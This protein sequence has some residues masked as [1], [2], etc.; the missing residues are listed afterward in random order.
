MSPKNLILSVMF[1]PPLCLC[2]H[3]VAAQYNAAMDSAYKAICTLPNDSAKLKKLLDFSIQVENTDT[4]LCKEVY[5]NTLSI[6]R[7]I[8]SPFFESKTL[9]Y[10]GIF[11]KNHKN[12]ATALGCLQ[13]A[14]KIARSA[15]IDENMG[16]ALANM[17]NV[18]YA[19]NNIE[20]ATVKS[21]EAV[22]HLEK[23]GKIRLLSIVLGNLCT[24]FENQRMY[25]K[26]I[27]YGLKAVQ[28]A[29]QSK[30]KRAIGL[31]YNNLSVPYFRIGDKEKSFEVSKLA[32]SCLREFK[33]HQNLHQ[34]YQ[35]I[36]SYY[37]EVNDV[38]NAR[39]YADSS[40]QMAIASNDDK[41][42]AKAK[43]LIGSIA[44]EAKDFAKAHK[45]ISEAKKMV[46]KNGEIGLQSD[47]NKLMFRL[48]D[49][50]GKTNESAVA[51]LGKQFL[52]ADSIKNVQILT[53]ITT[54]E[55]KFETEKKQLQIVQLQKEKKIQELSLHQKNIM[56]YL[57]L[58]GL[59]SAFAIGFLLYRNNR[60][61]HQIAA[62]KEALHQQQIKE[63]E[64]EKQLLAVSGM[65]QSQ[66]AERSRMAKD[67]HDGLGGMLSGIKLNLSSMKG[68]MLV[69]EKDALLF[70]K[71]ISQLDGAISEMRRVAHNMM[72]EA[73]LKF[74]I[75]EAVQDYS[76]SINESGMVKMRFTHLGL[77]KAI[78]KPTE[79]ILYRIIQEL[80][81]NAIKHAV[82]S[83]IFIQLTRHAKGIS[84]TVE[85]DGKGF[86]VAQTTKGAGLQN[87]QSRL[88]YLNG[89][90]EINSTPG[91]GSTFNVEIPM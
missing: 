33:N 39:L 52:L 75:N 4:I 84:L 14:Y 91:V 60:R 56:L 34:C 23:A 73:L 1:M 74:G 55:K 48:E 80:S 54:L 17:S 67:L 12:T 15:D 65:L 85:D 25:D 47:W 62:Q 38:P 88:D 11:F 8:N 53:N 46:D 89:S 28:A 40:L 19:E 9:I 86:D 7:N 13:Q 3:R 83:N 64:K 43:L 59:L 77:D 24:D 50:K 22:Q 57:L 35:N 63:L 81:N 68:N 10:K 36:S 82:A 45:E 72:P 78:E 49:A 18:Y 5:E 69:H 21:I 79:V 37:I 29:L 20:E 42:I 58:G 41:L 44:T 27:E 16:S 87:V 51:F 30:D 32:L 6:A 2:V 90:L 66:E 31:A 26:S 70:S 61:K 76:D 71:S